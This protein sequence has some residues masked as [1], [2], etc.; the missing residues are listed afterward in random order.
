MATKAIIKTLPIAVR[1]DILE[2]AFNLESY[3]LITQAIN[4]K[5]ALLLGR[6]T[7]HKF[8]STF[9]KKFNDLISLGMPIKVIVRYQLHIEAIGIDLIKKQLVERLMGR[10]EHL[11]SYLD[12]QEANQ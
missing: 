5:Y 9:F 12:E 10:K 8:T 7:V 6:T 1:V 2:R 11:F 4:E 3:L